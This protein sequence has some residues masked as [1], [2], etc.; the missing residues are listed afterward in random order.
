MHPLNGVCKIKFFF[1]KISTKFD[2][3]DGYYSGLAKRKQLCINVK[4]KYY[5]KLHTIP[6]KNFNHRIE[7]SIESFSYNIHSVSGLIEE[8]RWQVLHWKDNKPNVAKAGQLEVITSY[9]KGIHWFVN[10]C[11]NLAV[12]SQKANVLLL[13]KIS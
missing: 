5:F 8:Q 9:G 1:Q 13:K 4:N 3:Y 2:Y 10:E 7:M 11:S 12:S 6:E